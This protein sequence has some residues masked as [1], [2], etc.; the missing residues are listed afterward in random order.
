MAFARRRRRRRR[1]RKL[2]RFVH[3]RGATANEA[4]PTRRR[5][6]VGEIGY[7]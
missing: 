3:A 1:R 6:E 7:I 4:G 2:F 5:E